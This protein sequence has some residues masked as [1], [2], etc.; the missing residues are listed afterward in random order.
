MTMPAM[1]NDGIG[2]AVIGVGRAHRAPV[3]IAVGH[4]RR[5]VGRGVASAPAIRFVVPVGVRPTVEAGSIVARP[6]VV[7]IPRALGVGRGSEAADNRASDEAA[8]DAR[9]PAA[10]SSSPM[11]FGRRRRGHRGQTKSADHKRRHCNLLHRTS[12]HLLRPCDNGKK[13]QIVSLS[14]AR[15]DRCCGAKAEQVARGSPSLKRT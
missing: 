10:P 2:S 13:W 4:G 5:I 6:A 3:A 11:G 1:P 15:W 8:C 14:R 12:F 9:S 7:A